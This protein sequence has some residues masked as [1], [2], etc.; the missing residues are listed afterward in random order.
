MLPTFVIIGAMKCGTTSLHNYLDE[1]PEVCM[2]RVK[3]TNFFVVEKNFGRG[4]AWYESLFARPAKAC[5]E[6]SPN[7]TKSCFFPGVPERMHAV[8]P[9]ARLIYVVRDPIERMVSQYL[10]HY[11][12]GQ[13]QRSLSE[14]L[15]ERENNRYLPLSKYHAELA[16][17]LDW[18]PLERV[19]VLTAEALRREREATLRRV[20]EF[21]GVDPNYQGR[22]TGREYHRTER[23]FAAGCGLI[24][25]LRQQRWLARW[26]P[27]R[28][29]IKPER[30][31]EIELSAEV[32]TWLIEQLAPDVA[33]LRRLTG[34]RLEGWCV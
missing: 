32:R 33:A 17:F 18:Y 8:L 16:R 20:F 12:G 25:A 24:K 3:E 26:L 22:R 4:L 28:L 5:G 10:H 29:A 23:K 27:K 6:A 31:P 11:A 9:A 15:G 30:P 1:H 21:V 14:A 2:P 13:E 19:Q 7:Y 34:E